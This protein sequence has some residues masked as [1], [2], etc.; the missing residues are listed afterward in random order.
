MLDILQQ[1]KPDDDG[2]YK[3]INYALTIRYQFTHYF[4]MAVRGERFRD[5]HQLIMTSNTKGGFSVDDYTLTIEFTPLENVLFGIE[6]RTFHS[7]EKIF[8]R[9]DNYV[10]DDKFP[11]TSQ[12]FVN[13]DQFIMAGFELISK[14]PQANVAG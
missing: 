3:S 10:R 13:R 6:G 11:V 2:Y 1:K 14:R 8:P 4:A 7:G 5:P 9:T 12:R